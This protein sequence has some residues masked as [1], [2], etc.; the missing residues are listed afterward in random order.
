MAQQQNNQ[1]QQGSKNDR[2]DN[3]QDK[4]HAGRQGNPDQ[5]RDAQ[6]QFTEGRGKNDDSSR[7]NR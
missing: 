6:G 1:N 3:K 4:M 5:Q 7:N 2:D